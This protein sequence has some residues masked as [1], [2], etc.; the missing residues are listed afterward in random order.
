MNIDS[1]IVFTRSM[2]QWLQSAPQVAEAVHAALLVTIGAHQTPH[3]VPWIPRKHGT[4]PVLNNAAEHLYSHGANG[5]VDI[6][7]RGIYGRHHKG[8]VRGSVQRPIIMY[9]KHG[10]RALPPRIIAA[11][12][13]TLRA[14]FWVAFDAMK[15][16]GTA[17]NTQSQAAA[18]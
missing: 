8:S 1:L 18:A 7:I 14:R 2:P 16:G 9:K 11:I 10:I 17:A 6:S 13:A 3:G 12:E 5:R 15:S 4:R